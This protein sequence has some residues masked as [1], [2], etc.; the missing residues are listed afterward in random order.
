MSNNDFHK[1]PFDEETQF[2]LDIFR[3]YLRSW[4]PVFLHSDKAVQRI[5]IFDFFA[6]PGCDSVG[7]PGSPLIASEE[8]KNALE[9]N[10]DCSGQD[11]EI[12]LYLNEPDPFRSH[13]LQHATIPKILNQNP[14]LNVHRAE[15]K[16]QPLFF[17]HIPTLSLYNVANFVL[18]DQFG[19]KE[20]TQEVFQKMI[21][22]SRTDM[23]FFVSSSIVNRM[24]KDKYLNKYLPPI[25]EKEWE[26][27][28]GSNVTRI[29]RTAYARWIP[30]GREY[31]L[32]SFSLKRQA[33]VYGLIF[34]SSHPLGIKK[35]LESAWK[36]DS[37]NGE[38][39]FDIDSDGIEKN[40]P[41]LFDD[42]NRTTKVKLFEKQLTQLLAERSF[43]TNHDLFL[44]GLRNGMLPSHVKDVIT[45]LQKTQKLPKQ[46]LNISYTAWSEQSPQAI[47]YQEDEQI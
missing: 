21:S 47:K 36:K 31:Y 22:L 20:I 33:N 42:M 10:A 7:K 32:A 6:G 23:M 17:Q 14:C 38:A 35:F 45:S 15:E 24:K 34:G 26:Q 2:K 44:Y 8:I 41:F 5:Q 13:F 12:H 18:L 1:K 46:K 43:Q 27:M 25:E 16:F 4:L 37:L 3:Q 28:N 9:K 29:L 40:S 30:T 39:D 19:V 11:Q